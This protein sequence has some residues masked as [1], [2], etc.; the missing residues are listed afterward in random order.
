MASLGGARQCI[1]DLVPE[2]MGGIVKLMEALRRL[3]EQ[4]TKLVDVFQPTF[5]GESA[6]CAPSLQISRDERSGDSYRSA[7]DD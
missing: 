7:D 1:D 4:R 2:L 6:L 3:I 5:G